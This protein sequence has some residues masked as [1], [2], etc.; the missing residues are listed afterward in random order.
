M[1]ETFDKGRKSD[2]GI[3]ACGD[4]RSQTGCCN[5]SE[6]AGRPCYTP[7]RSIQ[8]AFALE[9]CQK[10]NLNDI[11]SPRN[12][13]PISVLAFI[14]RGEEEQHQTKHTLL[15]WTSLWLNHGNTFAS[16]SSRLD[17]TL[18][19]LVPVTCTACVCVCLQ[20]I[21]HSLPQSGKVIQS[22]I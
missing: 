5:W 17:V 12:K 9:H 11:S 8:F 14:K 20:T 1:I 3:E 22:S 15:C 2:L 10:S 16:P 7:D 18:H 13:S 21:M 19:Y 6:K 4:K